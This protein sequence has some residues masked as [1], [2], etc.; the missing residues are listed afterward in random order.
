MLQYKKYNIPLEIQQGDIDLGDEMKIIDI[1]KGD[2]PS[3]F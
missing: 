2:K 1:I 3:F